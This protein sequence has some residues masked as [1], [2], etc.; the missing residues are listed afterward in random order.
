MTSLSFSQGEFLI[1]IDTATGSYSQIGNPINGIGWVYP[2]IRGYDEIH[3]V[4]IFQGGN[5]SVDHLYSIDVTNGSIIYNPYFTPSGTGARELKHDNANDS[6]YGL[7]W[8]SSLSQF[9][10]A[11]V[12]P[13]SGLCTYITSNPIAGL[14]GTMQGATAYDDIHHRYFTLQSNQLFSIDALSGNLISS[15]VLSLAPGD[16]LSHFC[17]NNTI[18][19]LNGLIQNSNT[20]LCYVAYINTITGAI[21][22]MGSGTPLGIGGGSSSIDRIN[23]RYIYTYTTGGSNFYITAAD[24]TNGN[25]ISNKLIPLGSGDNIHSISF[26][27]VRGKLYGIQWDAV[28]GSITTLNSSDVINISP[29]PFSTQTTVQITNYDMQNTSYKFEMYDVFGRIVKQL[30]ISNSP[31]VIERDNLPSGLY[32]IRLTPSPSGSP[33]NLGGDSE[34]VATEKLVIMD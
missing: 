27:N 31:F 18:D 16:Q 1:E 10:M 9:F 2:Y 33:P 4:Y 17:Y 23:Q 19:T 21:T 6:L 34:G 7:Y 13:S 29:N 3:G 5:P 22:K 28:I 26:D 8:N 12:N 30:V 20:Q 11:T 32:F 14:N 25:I 15:P 24:I